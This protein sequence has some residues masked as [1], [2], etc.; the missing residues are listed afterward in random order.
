[1]LNAIDF[2]T[3]AYILADGYKADLDKLN[4]Q[5]W[6]N[7]NDMS[8]LPGFLATDFVLGI[9]LVWT[10]A[11]I[12]PRFGAGAGTAMRAG[13]L[14]GL[15][16]TVFGYY[17]M[18]AGL[19]SMNTF[20]ISSCLSIVNF[21]VSAWVGGKLCTE[22]ACAE[23]VPRVRRTVRAARR[24]RVFAI[25]KSRLLPRRELRHHVADLLLELAGRGARGLPEVRALGPVAHRLNACEH[26]RSAV[27]IRF[28]VAQQ[29]QV[30]VP[31]LGIRR[32]QLLSTVHDVLHRQPRDVAP[33]LQVVIS[34][35][36]LLIHRDHR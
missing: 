19:F 28:D 1:M 14:F 8:K 26:L 2:V 12:R 30:D 10:Y 3:N 21:L 29:V 31:R 33:H 11:A 16:G 36:E 27:R 15:F 17:L 22:A 25:P 5:L 4:P 23:A 18:H 24:T 34:D 9:L 35:R 6:A 20:L 7:M 32:A 13:L